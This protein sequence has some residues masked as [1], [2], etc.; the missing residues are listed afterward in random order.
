MRASAW[1][2]V[3]KWGEG[4]QRAPNG[5]LHLARFTATTGA[6]NRV[7][8]GTP[9]GGHPPKGKPEES[10]GRCRARSVPESGEPQARGRGERRQ[11]GEERGPQRERGRL[12]PDD[13]TGPGGALSHFAHASGVSEDLPVRGCLHGMCI[14]CHTLEKELGRIAIADHRAEGVGKGWAEIRKGCRRGSQPRFLGRS[15]ALEGVLCASRAEGEGWCVT[16]Q[17]TAHD[18]PRQRRERRGPGVTTGK[19]GASDRTTMST[20]PPALRQGDIA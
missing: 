20:Q 6:E 12:R 5:T 8:G 16:C 10:E 18:R 11:A 15:R 17:S 9:Q 4:A 3:R 7:G 19:L 14:A 1:R 13:V 2:P